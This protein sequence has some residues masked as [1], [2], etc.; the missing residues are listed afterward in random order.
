MPDAPA[1]S[2][3]SARVGASF[4]GGMPGRAASARLRVTGRVVSTAGGRPRG[5]GP[6]AR[7]RAHRPRRPGVVLVEA[8]R[9]AGEGVTCVEA[10]PTDCTRARPCG[11]GRNPCPGT[12]RRMRGP[13][14]GSRGAG[15]GGATNCRPYAHPCRGR[16]GASG[17]GP[18]T[19]TASAARVRDGIVGS[20]LRTHAGAGA[21]RVRRCPCRRCV[22]PAGAARRARARGKASRPRR[23]RRASCRRGQ[24]GGRRR[25]PP[26]S[27]RGRARGKVHAD[28]RGTRG[29]G[30]WMGA[31]SVSGLPRPA[32]G[33]GC[34]GRPLSGR[35]TVSSAPSRGTHA[36]DV[37]G[38][39]RARHPDAAR[40]TRAGP[41]TDAHD[42]GPRFPGPAVDLRRAPGVRSGPAPS[43]R[44][45][46]RLW[47]EI[48][49]PSPAPRSGRPVQSSGGTKRTTRWSMAPKMERPSGSSI[50]IRTRSPQ[51][52]NGVFASPSRM[53][54][55]MRCSAMQE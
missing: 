9:P 21:A 47:A 7:E 22:R 54:S 45:A 43:S 32:R 44:A 38:C 17:G 18:V 53:I 19:L 13:V 10:R 49:M 40:A 14:R 25:R 8:A 42:I 11:R 37:A 28:P 52:R 2:G 29:A 33:D 55:T 1:L 30:R 36:G 41:G 20:T 35:G 27:P 16:R 24:L 48:R 4:P 15:P 26:A 39:G 5:S 23:R 3:P 50:S 12:R 31:G 34:C 51:R 6:S 46:A